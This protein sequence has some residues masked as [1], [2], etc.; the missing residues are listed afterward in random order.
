MTRSDNV[1]INGDYSGLS[2]IV[3]P[4]IASGP[5]LADRNGTERYFTMWKHTTTLGDGKVHTFLW[6]R[7]C[8]YA[9]SYTYTQGSPTWIGTIS[10]YFENVYVQKDSLPQ[11]GPL[12][13]VLLNLDYRIII[14]MNRGAALF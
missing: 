11:I 13:D 1:T 9:V 8:T 6:D 3:T 7:F 2:G 12:S 10:S 5:L 4:A 14:D